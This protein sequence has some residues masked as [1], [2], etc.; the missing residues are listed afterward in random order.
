M[1]NLNEAIAFANV[2]TDNTIQD[3]YATIRDGIFKGKRS[4]VLSVGHCGASGCC[5]GKT[6]E[7]HIDRLIRDKYKVESVQGKNCMYAGNYDKRHYQIS[8]WSQTKHK[9]S[10]HKVDTNAS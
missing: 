8:G 3:T 10:F 9:R 1:F 6:T 7:L 4:I 5:D 2:E